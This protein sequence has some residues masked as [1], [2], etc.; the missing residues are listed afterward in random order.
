MDSFAK[1]G[2]IGLVVFIVLLPI[3]IPYYLLKFLVGR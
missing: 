1:G 3:L 2:I